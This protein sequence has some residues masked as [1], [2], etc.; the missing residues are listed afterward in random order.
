MME[1]FRYELDIAGKQVFGS[2]F[3]PLT[4]GETIVLERRY[5]VARIVRYPTVYRNENGRETMDEKLVPL[6]VLEKI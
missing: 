3:F 1:K 2:F 5:R 6:A 4:V